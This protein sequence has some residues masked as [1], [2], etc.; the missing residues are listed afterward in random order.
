MVVDFLNAK[1]KLTEFHGGRRMK[2]S[3]ME[4]FNLSNKRQSRL[5][6]AGLI[7]DKYIFA[8]PVLFKGG[9]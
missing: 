2:L 5:W 4:L 9:E 8:D 6:K 7:M 1:L 3:N